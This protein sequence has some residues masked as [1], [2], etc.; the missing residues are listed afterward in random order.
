MRRR[1]RSNLHTQFTVQLLAIDANNMADGFTFTVQA[2]GPNALGSSGSGLGHASDPTDQTQ[3]SANIPRSVAVTFNVVNNT[4][5]LWRDG[6]N[7]AP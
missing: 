5:S 1:G 2:V 6:A 3:T 4:V 7:G